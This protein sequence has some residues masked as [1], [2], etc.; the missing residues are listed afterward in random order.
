[1]GNTPH[2]RLFLPKLNRAEIYIKLEGANPTSSIKDRAAWALVDKALRS[3]EY[4]N[5]QH[6]IATSSGNFGCGV[7][8]YGHL[9]GIPSY[10]LTGRTLTLDKKHFM[11]IFGAE[12]IKHDG[13]TI[14]GHYK[15]VN[16]IIPHHPNQYCYLDQLHD[17]ANVAIHYK[18]TGPEI[19]ADFPDIVGVAFSIGSGATLLGTTKYLKEKKPEVKI[20]ASTG[21]EGSRIPGTGDFDGGEYK[22]PFYKELYS[23]N[24]VDFTY[25]VDEQS[26]KEIIKL[27][28]D[29]GFFVGLQTAGVVVT[30]IKAIEELNITGK[31]VVISGDSGWK[32]ADKLKDI[33]IQGC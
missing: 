24:L 5:G 30:A 11:E 32:N 6:F 29:Q 28:I 31:V 12:I 22:T 8:Y 13:R 33:F 20:I 7:A 26:C 15:I 16:E 19:F 3:G 10:I 18:T 17:S 25:K 4:K 21:A 9:Y 1:M 23:S 14:D 2:I 27:L